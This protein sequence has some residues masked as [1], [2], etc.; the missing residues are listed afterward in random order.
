MR[1]LVWQLSDYRP[2]DARQADDGDCDEKIRPQ[3][4]DLMK[5]VRGRSEAR[6]WRRCHRSSAVIAIV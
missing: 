2:Q 5:P 6:I 3:L 1:A 4:K